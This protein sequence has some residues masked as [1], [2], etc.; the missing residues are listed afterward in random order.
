MRLLVKILIGLALLWCVYWGI[1]A[2][3]LKTGVSAWLDAQRQQ[4]WAADVDD[5]RISGFPFTFRHNMIGL[6]VA[7]P[8]TGVAWDLPNLEIAARAWAPND[9]TVTWPKEQRLCTVNGA[10]DSTSDI[11]T[12]NLKLRPS[13]SMALDTAQFVVANLTGR[14]SDGQTFS[15]ASAAGSFVLVPGCSGS[16]PVTPR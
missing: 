11:M 9:V 12:A 16:F 7:D 15:V 14:L 13:T 3:S 4:G 6:R 10:L 2:Y 1:G 8:N 5:S